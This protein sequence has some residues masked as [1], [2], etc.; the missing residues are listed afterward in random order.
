L[1]LAGCAPTLP[2]YSVHVPPAWEQAR[3]P[4]SIVFLATSVELAPLAAALEREIP[5]V[6]EGSAQTR[7]SGRELRVSWKLRRQAAE[8]R[9]VERG[10]EVR[11]ALRGTVETTILGVRCQ[12]DDLEIVRTLRGRPSLRGWNE[13]VLVGEPRFGGELRGELRC[14]GL[15]LPL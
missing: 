12:S 7:V 11:I 1:V 6:L 15:P 9:A 3:P 13:L 8:L 10:V 14:L 2:P 5:P 4:T